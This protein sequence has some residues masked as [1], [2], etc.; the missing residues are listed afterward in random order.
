MEADKD[1]KIILSSGARADHV[2]IEACDT[3]KHHQI[4]PQKFHF[5]SKSGHITQASACGVHCGTLFATLLG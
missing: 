3:V 2:G 4:Q 5:D 1:F